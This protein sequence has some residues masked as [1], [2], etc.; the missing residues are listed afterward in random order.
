MTAKPCLVVLAGPADD[1]FFTTVIAPAVEAA[2]LHPIRTD[3]GSGTASSAAM[4][5]GLVALQLAEVAI[6]D[7]GAATPDVFVAVGERR[8]R[9]PGTT[10]LLDH[11]GP[12]TIAHP[13][14]PTVTYRVDAASGR[15]L[16]VAP[17]IDHL[18]A[19]LTHLGGVDAAHRLADI[20]GPWSGLPHAKTDVFHTVVDDDSTF[21][22]A[23]IAARVE[24]DVDA[25]RAAEMG[26]GPL[27]DADP[28]AVVDLMLSYR[29]V[30]DASATIDLVERMP[31]VL[32]DQT[33]VREQFAFALNRVGRSA[34]AEAVLSELIED[35]G[36]TPENCA[37]LGRVYKQ[38]ARTAQRAGNDAAA[39]ADLERAIAAYTAGFESDWRDA[40]PGINAVMLMSE[41]DPD[42]PRI[43]ELATVVG[44]S[45]ERKI[46]TTGGDFW[47]RATL[48]QLSV[49]AHDEEGAHVRLAALLAEPADPW[50]R[51]TTAESLD[52]FAAHSGLDW[53]RGLAADV[54][55]AN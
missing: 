15:P 54:R 14:E 13:E 22:A 21:T 19:T 25:L 39:R 31:P 36:P 38:R 8:A 32:A 11:D 2:G 41:H 18:V 1:E 27:D 23:L 7:L 12:G 43:D 20:L 37:L 26:L 45:V 53:V 24:G 34:E 16:D 5:S 44:Y 29:A 50:M 47:D 6:V 42:D 4:H 9:R 49:A 51:T 46:A 40:F 10:V 17:T 3:V 48:V 35:R 30:D 52:A 28:A 55:A 33:L